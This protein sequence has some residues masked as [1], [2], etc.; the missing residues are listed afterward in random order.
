MGKPTGFMEWVRQPAANRPPLER[1]KDWNEDPH[2]L[3]E[4]E[5]VHQ[6][7]RCMDCGVPYCHTGQL[8]SGMAAGCP[9][10]NLIPEWNDLVYRGQW[11]EAI[12]RLHADRKSTRLNSS[13]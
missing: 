12:V 7:G 8:I 6:A 5:M 13:H 4:L 1:I 11:K 2:K 3:P 10:N 9:I